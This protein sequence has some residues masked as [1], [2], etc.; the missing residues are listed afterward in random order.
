MLITFANSLDDGPDLG[1]NYLTL[2]LF[3]KEFSKKMILKKISR[4]QKNLKNCPV[5][6][7]LLR[8]MLIMLQVMWQNL[9][10]NQIQMCMFLVMVDTLG[11][12]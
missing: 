7:E 9:C 2:M 12:W 5:G 1:Q 3:L 11:G 10:R 6:K 4:Q 8:V